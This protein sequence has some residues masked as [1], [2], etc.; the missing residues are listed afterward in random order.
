MKAKRMI[1]EKI[2][3]MIKRRSQEKRFSE[4]GENII[5]PKEVKRSRIT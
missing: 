3:S 1:P 5:V 2:R 4:K